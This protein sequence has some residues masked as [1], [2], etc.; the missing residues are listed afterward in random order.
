ML[1]IQELEKG[2]ELEMLKKRE[3]D[4]QIMKEDAEK[5]FVNLIIALEKNKTRQRELE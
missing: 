1:K 3:E 2:L 5:T 4:L